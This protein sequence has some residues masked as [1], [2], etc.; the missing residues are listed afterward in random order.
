MIW[1]IISAVLVLFVSIWLGEKRFIK[2]EQITLRRLLLVSIL[3]MLVFLLLRYLNNLGYFPQPIGAAFMTNCYSSFS[4]FF[5][6][7]AY[8]QFK[9]KKDLGDID[10]VN[11]AFISDLL[12]N[13]LALTII[14]LGIA[15]TSIFSEQTVSPIRLSSGISLIAIGIYAVTLKVT[16]E[17]RKK[18]FVILDRE[19]P[20]KDLISYNW[21]QEQVIELE[22]KH[23]DQLRI[24]RSVV[25]PEDEK[26]VEK[27]LSK[28][29]I[30][31]ME[32]EA[33]S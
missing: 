20:W 11:T 8:A 29:M 12:P 31:K 27:L 26:E 16:P 2:L 18:G 24:H 25:A 19:I 30:E 14:I 21:Y 3:M 10:Y 13:L 4:G 9:M 22:F 17:F 5:F 33:D 6:G 7:A 15:R 32:K 28:K 23:K 1:T